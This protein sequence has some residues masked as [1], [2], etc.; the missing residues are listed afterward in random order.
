MTYTVTSTSC[1]GPGS[2]TEAMA[3]ANANPGEDTISFTAGLQ[4]DAGQ[5]LPGFREPLMITLWSRRPS[6]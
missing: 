2:I 6:R 1:T 4:I 5:C 3:K